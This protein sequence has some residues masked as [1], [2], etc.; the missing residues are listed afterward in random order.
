MA[1][2]TD[3]TL[4]SWGNNSDGKLGLG[5]TTSSSSPT[6]VGALTDWASVSCAP[7][8]NT[9]AIT[10]G[11]VLYSW[12]RNEYG[13]LGTNNTTDYSSPKQV[14]VLTTWATVSAGHETTLAT[15][16]DG[17]LWAWGYT[18]GG[19]LGNGDGGFNK[20]SSPIQVGASTDWSK[21]YHGYG[22]SYGIKTGG[23]LWAWG[24]NSVGG[25]GLGDIS[26]RSSPSQVGALSNWLDIAGYYNWAVAIKTDGT[27]WTWGTNGSGQLG[28]NNRTS[29]SSPK[30]VGALTSWAKI[31]AGR[32]TATVLA[33][34]TDGTL[35]AWGGNGNGQLGFGNITSY[36][37]PKQVGSSTNWLTASIA[38][39]S[40][41]INTTTSN[42]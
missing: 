37:S 11:G 5:S 18:Q 27:L 33:I 30:Q 19:A 14:G 20:V 1:I 13:Q 24:F 35:W 32:S 29:Y 39:H 12:G 21:T 28:L 42:L 9:S 3:G 22:N 25:L 40:L 6:Q 10:T 26:D 41:G 4:W 23:T 16:T 38:S 15:K 34:K 17:T 31:F 36:S 2:K 8:N 7:S